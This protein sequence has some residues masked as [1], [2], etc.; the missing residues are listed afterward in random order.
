MKIMDQLWMD[1]MATADE[2]GIEE[3]NRV[4]IGMNKENW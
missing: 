2:G 1:T 4:E 3:G